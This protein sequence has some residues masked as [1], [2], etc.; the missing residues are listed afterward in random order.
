MNFH[1]ERRLRLQANPDTTLY[2]WGINE[3]DSDGQVIGHDQIPWAWGLNF[4]TDELTVRD[5]FRYESRDGLGRTLEGTEVRHQSM[6]RAKLVPGNLRP[7]LWR[8]PTF[9]MFGTDRV[10][11]NFQ[12][13]I[14]AE[15]ADRPAGCTTWGSVSYTSEIDFRTD[16]TDDIVQFYLMV[17]QA[18]YDIWNIGQGLA[19][20][21]A[22]SVGHVDGFYSEWSPSISTNSI[23]V[24]AGDEH[25]VEGA[26]TTKLPRLGKVGQ[27]EFYMHA[28]RDLRRRD[29]DGAEQ[30]EEP[31]RKGFRWP[32]VR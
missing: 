5:S 4:V 17:P 15:T 1:L 8:E 18:T 19:D 27:A 14:T 9:R 26:E 11:E 12:L 22:F 32:G 16:T 20:E 31:A 23:K 28:R 29:D 3:L 2:K 24:L 13:D 10:I 21:V 7:G 25:L 30:Q 6:I